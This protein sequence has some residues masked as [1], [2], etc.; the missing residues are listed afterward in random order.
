VINY[1]L[2][3]NPV[4]LIQRLGR[5]DRIG[6]ENERVWGF[7]FLPELKLERNLGLHDILR[8][9]IQEIHDSIGEDAAILDKD[10]QINEEAMFAIYEKKGAQLTLFEDEEGEFLDIS[11]AEEYMRSLRTKEPDEYQR[12]AALRDGIRSS[13][14]VFSGT[15]RY[16]LCQAGKYQQLF[17]TDPNGEI[18]SREIPFVL[19][20]IK[21]SRA[22][23]AAVLPKDHNQIVMKVLKAFSDEVS[24]RKAQLHH[25]L[26][27]TTSQNY[28]LRELR[29]F[30]SQ[31]K[32]ED[33]DLKAQV[34]KLEEAF[35]R[36]VTA[37]LRR[38]LNTLRRNGVIGNLLVRAMTDLYHDHGLQDRVYEDRRLHEQESEELPRVICSEAF[39]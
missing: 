26:S 33:T 34:V 16:V 2:H 12:I 8:R 22:E 35:K 7:N 27:L 37:A 25:G 10:E 39:V 20:R 36:P 19:S 31:L 6:S 23:P 29:A 1:D 38:Q 3:W 4:R 14:G 32:D 17:L 18:R 15:G 9:R 13:R 5:I 28:V 24:H 11:E 30:Y 21:C